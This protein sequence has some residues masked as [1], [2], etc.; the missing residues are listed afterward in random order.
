MLA[1]DG[2]CWAVGIEDTFVAQPWPGTGRSLDEYALTRH[3]E[4]WREDLERVAWLGVSAV[5]YGVPWHRVHPAPG[6]FDFGFA[7]DTLGWL[8][9][10]GITPIV[11]LVHYGTPLWLEGAFL[12]PDYPRHVAEY[13][14]AL[15]ERFRGRLRWITPMNEPR[16][17]AWYA[18]K[19]GWWPPNERGWGGFLRV[20]L[21]ACRGIHATETAL[22][23]LD[24]ELRM[25]HVDA[26]DL[27]ESDDPALAPD[28]ARRQELVFLALDLL[29]G[30][31]DAEH[32]LHGWLSQ[33]GVREAELAEFREKP[34][35]PDVVGINLY[36]MFSRKRVSRA[37]GRLRVRMLRAGPEILVRL[38]SLYHRRYGRP[39]FVSETAALG[40]HAQRLAWLRASVDAVRRARAS[41]IP[42]VGYTWWPLFALVA[43]A[44]RQSA[45]RDLGDHLLQMGLW[46]LDPADLRRVHTP[47][48]DAY[49]SLASAG[50]AA[51]S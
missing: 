20:L 7:D 38:A 14:C 35:V 46:D 34:L 1:R 8:L 15:A 50:A 29:T 28:C 40:S 30:R 41:G 11:D 4:C 32:P 26:T 51:A 33:H 9:E 49:R 17:A 37:H 25:L 18:G 2:F 48:A 47:V 5:R 45:A 16:I 12:H 39:I 23:E 6:R 10:R 43:W 36:P 13:A 31:V 24:P 21:A 3:Y 42:V 44:Y 19:L 22:R 27:Y